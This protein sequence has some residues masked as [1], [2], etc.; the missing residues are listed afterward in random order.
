MVENGKKVN[1]EKKRKRMK[2]NQIKTTNTI[3][4]HNLT[5]KASHFE[6]K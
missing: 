1:K 3:N 6:I 2:N 4:F 5:I